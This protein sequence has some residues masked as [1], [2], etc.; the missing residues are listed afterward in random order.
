M[1]TAWAMK[2]QCA[3]CEYWE[4]ERQLCSDP[5]VVECKMSDLGLCTG[6][7]GAYR[8]KKVSAGTCVGKRCWACWHCLKM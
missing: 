7:D 1:A 8:G 5:R 6:P 3:T 4:G 2:K